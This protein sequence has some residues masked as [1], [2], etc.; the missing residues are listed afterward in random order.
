[1]WI[2]Y[3]RSMVNIW[4][5][6]VSLNV[7]GVVTIL[8][9][10]CNFWRWPMILLNSNSF[11]ACYRCIT[12]LHITSQVNWLDWFTYLAFTAF[13]KSKASARPKLPK[14]I[15]FDRRLT[16]A[17]TCI[18]RTVQRHCSYNVIMKFS[19][20]M[21]QS[22]ATT[23]SLR[24]FPYCGLS[25]YARLYAC[26]GTHDARLATLYVNLPAPFTCG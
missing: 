23:S 20:T 26:D 25:P 5:L 3:L 12:Y 10:K 22:I 2:M 1:M 6:T 18:H 14:D 21:E 19:A 4:L 8:R 7:R 24:V 17:Q 15:A 9:L 11:N 16:W 13:Q